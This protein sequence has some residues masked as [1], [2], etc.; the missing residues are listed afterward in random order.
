MDELRIPV[1]K[2]GGGYVKAILSNGEETVFGRDLGDLIG[3]LK[4]RAQLLPVPPK[5]VAEVLDI[6]WQR[7]R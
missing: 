2:M 4:L 6:V 1:V 5:Y 7:R 3:R